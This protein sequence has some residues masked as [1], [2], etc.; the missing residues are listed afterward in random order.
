M[1]NGCHWGRS[2]VYQTEQISTFAFYLIFA[3]LTLTSV[4]W[5]LLK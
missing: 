2:D 4:F 1:Q 5:N 3:K